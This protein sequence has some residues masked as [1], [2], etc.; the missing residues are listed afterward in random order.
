MAYNPATDFLALWRNNAGVVSK[1]E[2]PGLDYV[3]AS[4]A[5]AG[6]ITLSVS[7]TA[8][9]VSQSTTAWLQTAVPSNSAEGVLRLWNPVTT[10]Y[11]AA[12]PALLFKMLET[13][14]GENGVSWWTTTGGA[15]ANVV[16]NDGDF[17]IR[18]DEPGGIYGPKALGAWPPSPIP[19]TTDIVSSAQLDLSFGTTEGLMLFRGPAVWQALPIGPANQVMA[20][21]GAD[22]LWSALS[23]LFDTL[24]GG[25][26]GSIL[27]RD[28][29]SWTTLL[30]D[31]AGD[32]LTTNGPGASPSWAPR[33]AEF[34]SG[35]RLTFNQSA[36]P[37]GWT[38][39]VTIND[40]GL[41][42]TN[43]VVGSVAG[44][45]FSAVFAQTNV[46][47]TTLS[48]AQMPSHGHTTDAPTSSGN[49]S[50]GGAG[51]TVGV[52][53]PGTAT[54]APNGGSGP[55]THSIALALAYVDVIIASKN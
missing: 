8:P 18:T 38:K 27:F 43:G 1:T 13:A 37:T 20:S 21:S 4:L 48:V 2:M 25:T 6:L 19:G 46:G 24:F 5:R 50:A 49:T 11:V 30:P 17:A 33:T 35:T 39:D 42:V 52:N 15:P 3:V 31:A 28:V 26:R 12:T 22:P 54:V 29:A 10:V 45:S 53:A 23:S 32:V 47:N 41:R 44:T 51:A 36:A 9:V 14:A 40:V 55:H 34:T 7:A 16:G